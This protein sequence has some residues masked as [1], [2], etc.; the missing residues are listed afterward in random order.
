[1]YG[2]DAADLELQR[3]AR[4]FTDELI[5][6]EAAAEEQDGRLPE[7]LARPS[8]TSGPSSSGSTPPTCRPRSADPD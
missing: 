7:E 5:A 4:G 6:C 1:M 3:R 2:L 8:T